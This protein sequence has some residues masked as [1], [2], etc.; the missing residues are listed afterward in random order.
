MLG[1][2]ASSD[3]AQI[4]AKGIVNGCHESKYVTH[5]RSF[6]DQEVPIRIRHAGRQLDGRAGV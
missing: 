5:D 3:G 6:L 2:P 4:H 1:S